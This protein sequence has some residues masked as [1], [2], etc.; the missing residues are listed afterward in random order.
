MK[1]LKRILRSLWRSTTREALADFERAKAKLDRVA[2]QAAAE[3]EAIRDEI[4][5][6]YSKVDKLKAEAM[7]EQDEAGRARRIAG[8]I[9]EL[10][11]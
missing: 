6:Y 11:K 2:E 5:E 7:A 1:K 10:L 3:V 4:E 8:R 9:N